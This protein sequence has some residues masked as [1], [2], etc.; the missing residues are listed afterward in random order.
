MQ[1]LFFLE[2]E[3]AY[4]RRRVQ[5]AV[6]ASGL[7]ARAIPPRATRRHLIIPNLI[8]TLAFRRAGEVFQRPWPML[9]SIPEGKELPAVQG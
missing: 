5:D 3:T 4:M 9:Q 2:I 7:A 6:V 8:L 1:N